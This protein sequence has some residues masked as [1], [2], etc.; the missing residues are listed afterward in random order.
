MPV[1]DGPGLGVVYDWDVIERGRLEQH[2]A[3][4]PTTSFHATG[5]MRLVS[6]HGEGRGNMMHPSCRRFVVAGGAA[7]LSG[8]VLSTPQR[9]MAAG[10]ADPVKVVDRWL[11]EVVR[12]GVTDHLEEIMQPNVVVV[13][14]GLG[15]NADGTPRRLEGLSAVRDWIT[16]ARSRQAAP[17]EIR[18]RRSSGRRQQGRPPSSKCLDDAIRRGSSQNGPVACGVLLC[19]CGPDLADRAL[20]RSH[21]AEGRLNTQVFAT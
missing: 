10:E 6:S 14:H 11:D 20:C 17:P 16:Q 4:G 8:A 19:R 15:A 2:M 5:N 1:P 18:I 12:Q 21:Q 7:T 3:V 9:L 13:L